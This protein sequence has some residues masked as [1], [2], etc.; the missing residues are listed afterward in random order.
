VKT[1]R[2]LG[3]AFVALLI[4]IAVQRMLFP[5]PAA[6]SAAQA[7]ARHRAPT[8]GRGVGRAPWSDGSSYANSGS[9]P[10][11]PDRPSTFNGNVPPP[12]PIA[13]T[14]D[15]RPLGGPLPSGGTGIDPRV[16]ESVVSGL[17]AYQGGPSLAG[18]TTRGPFVR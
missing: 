4:I 18:S 14:A 11:W 9:Q 15:G 2:L 12:P 17:A 3:I 16:L 10:N 13:Y 7:D 5:A 6:P 1:P 8:Y